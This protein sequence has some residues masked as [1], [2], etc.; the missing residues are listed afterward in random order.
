MRILKIEVP[1]VLQPRAEGLNLNDEAVTG[2][3]YRELDG[4]RLELAER[5]RAKAVTYLPATYTVFVR[6]AFERKGNK[7]L[8][9]FWIDDPTVA[10]FSGV[11]ARRAWKLSTPIL[12]HVFREAVQERLQTIAVEVDEAK[13]AVSAFAP[14][15]A[16]YS[17]LAI[18]V[19]VMA[20]SALYWLF[21]HGSVVSLLHRTAG[22]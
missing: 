5:I 16:W 7:A 3:L 2:Q 10:G 8:A 6:M 19:Y 9:T 18:T 1:G 14:T 17:P 21:A 20:V 11:L 4:L 15:R 22:Q 13:A 12:A